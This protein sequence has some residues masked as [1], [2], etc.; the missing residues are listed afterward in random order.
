[1]TNSLR[2]SK[3]RDA[4]R[5]TFSSNRNNN[6]QKTGYKDDTRQIAFEAICQ[7]MESSRSLDIAFETPL[8][9]QANIRDRSAAYRLANCVLRNKGSLDAVIEPFLQKSPPLQLKWILLLGSAQ[10]LFLDTPHHAAVDTSV[11]LA[12]NNNLARFTGVVNAVLHKII[13]QQPQILEGIDRA[14]LNLPNWLWQSWSKA[15]FE[16]RKI[17]ACFDVEAPLDLT[18]RL[19]SMAPEGGVKLPNGSWRYPASTKVTT[20]QGFNEGQFWVQD[21]AATLPA[22]LLN[23]QP[24]EKIADLCAAPGGK[25]AQLI[26]TGGKVTAVE[27]EEKRLRVLNNNLDRLHLSADIV[28]ADATKLE[29]RDYF[30]AILLDAPCSATG[31][32]RRHPDVLYLKK[33]KNIMTLVKMQRNLIHS[34]LLYLKPGGRF[35]YSVCSLQCEEA[36]EQAKW[37]ESLPGVKG[38]PFEKE[39]ISFLPQ[40]LTKEGYIRTL[41]YFWLDQGGMDGFFMARFCRL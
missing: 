36:E 41:P 26:Q 32:L 39:E 34:V 40:A 24:N 38:M 5:K 35:I 25:T 18:L 13:R 9:R 4:F 14:R 1:M 22:L 16:P 37:I 29:Y 33:P 3:E 23:V 17:A 31:I 10:I 2:K 27:K 8:A 19:G 7:V 15:G 21:F 6:H 12:R 30:D 28:H 20:L 11:N